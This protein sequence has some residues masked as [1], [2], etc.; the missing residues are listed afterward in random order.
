LHQSKNY[1]SKSFIALVPGDTPKL[2]RQQTE[3]EEEGEE[4]IS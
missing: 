4:A 2:D 1:G 3:A